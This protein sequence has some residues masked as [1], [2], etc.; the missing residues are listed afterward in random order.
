MRL[1]SRKIWRA[2][3]EL[4]QYDDATC[5]RYIARARQVRR[6]ALH[7]TAIMFSLVASLAIAITLASPHYYALRWIA[8]QF[9][10]NDKVDVMTDTL[11]NLLVFV[12]FIWVPALTALIV[13][14]RLLHRCVRRHLDGAICPGCRYSLI[15]L[16]IFGPTGRSKVRCPEC[17][18]EIRLNHHSLTEADINPLL[19]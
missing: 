10:V 17:G 4:D 15:G 1:I 12:S 9:W 13:R 3:P 16:E 2:F 8:K 5:H 11:L 7:Q 6:T 19:A 14:D 18:D